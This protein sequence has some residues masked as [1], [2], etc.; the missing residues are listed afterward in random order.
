[1]PVLEVRHL[2]LIDAVTARGGITAAARALHV[3]QPALSRQLSE[4]EAR[5]GV[6]LFAR[7]GRRLVI[8]KAGERLLASSRRVLGELDA[9]E[10]E[11]T[12][13]EYAGAA[14]LVRVATEC[15]TN[16]HWLPAV[17]VA[18]R[19]HWPR[20]DV[21]IVP[22]ATARPLAALL[23]GALDVAV[24]H[25]TPE[26]RGLQYTHLFDDEMV[27]VVPPEH[28]LA[29]LASVPAE[30]IRD[31]HLILYATSGN[32]SSVV[33]N[34]LRPAGV[35]PRQ[36]SR[37]QLTEAILELVRA[38]LGITI[39]SRWSVERH[40]ASGALA[41]VPLTDTGYRR[42]W[43]AATRGDV[44]QPPYLAQF[45]ALLADSRFLPVDVR[46][47]APRAAKRGPKHGLA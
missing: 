20:V 35:E 32:E 9:V 44:R 41:A 45:L 18:F 46:A 23:E 5:L 8:T 14:G 25:R 19:E 40:V 10:R 43:Y 26:Q 37:I 29:R 30:A 24:V 17:L 33:T 22:E 6:A 34:V 42:R 39:L 7:V 15:Y 27:V 4:L 31:E 2:R 1:M 36:L 21:R 12:S 13:G 47:G 38:G 28:R 11:L 3:T 16:Y